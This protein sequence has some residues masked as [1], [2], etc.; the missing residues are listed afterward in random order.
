[1]I[2]FSYDKDKN[3]VSVGT[4]FDEKEHNLTEDKICEYIIS[5]LPSEYTYS[6]LKK[7]NDYTSIVVDSDKYPNALDIARL[8]YTERAKWIKVALQ[9]DDSKLERDNPIFREQKNKNEAF[10]KVSIRNEKDIDKLIPFIEKW[11]IYQ[12]SL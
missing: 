5:K 2:K 1:M 6:V 8:K 3:V 4:Q 9:N 11:T 10:W 12:K 7:S